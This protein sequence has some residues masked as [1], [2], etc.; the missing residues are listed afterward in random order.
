M[1]A[2]PFA[3]HTPQP[4]PAAVAAPADATQRARALIF[5]LASADQTYDLMGANLKRALG[6]ER[7]TLA[8][9]PH[10][11]RTEA[12]IALREAEKLVEHLKRAVAN[13]P[14]EG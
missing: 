3:H 8:R 9:T 14:V 7:N 13:L 4:A 5:A 6:Y 2:E 11:V 12:Q 1:Y 10:M